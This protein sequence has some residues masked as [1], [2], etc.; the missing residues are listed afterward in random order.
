MAL[1]R[2]A[3]QMVMANL[4]MLDDATEAIL[5]IAHGDGTLS[6]HSTT[7][8]LHVQVGLVRSIELRLEESVRRADAIPFVDPVEVL[9]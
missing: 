8:S 7:D 1:T 9:Q 3:K 5:I 6:N 2:T 4:D